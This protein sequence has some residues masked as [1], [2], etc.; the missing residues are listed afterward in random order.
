MKRIG[1]T[2]PEIYL[3]TADTFKNQFNMID[4]PFILKPIM[5]SGSKGVRIINSHK[6]LNSESNTI[7]Y[8]EKFITGVHYNVYFIDNEIC[9]LIKPPLAHEHV[10][11]KK[12]RTPDDIRELINKWRNYFAGDLIFG[13]LDIVREE[14]SNNLYIVDPGSFPEFTNWKCSNSP[15]ES[16]CNLIINKFK[17]IKKNLS[18]I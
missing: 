9:T 11:M 14:S 4:F 10:D 15:S 7:L 2:A 6:D 12:I 17:K 3:G 8:L 18:S 1:L 5:G 13:H 16:I